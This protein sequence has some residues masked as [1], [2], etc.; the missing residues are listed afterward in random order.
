MNSLNKIKSMISTLAIE[1]V[2]I[3]ASLDLFFFFNPTGGCPSLP[4][5]GAYRKQ[6]YAYIASD[7]LRLGK[8]LSIPRSSPVGRAGA[9]ANGPG[10]RCFL[11]GKATAISSPEGA[12][13]NSAGH[14]MGR[15]RRHPKADTVDKPD[16]RDLFS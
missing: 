12:T 10:N 2:L 16:G 8:L 11:S 6:E 7:P 1:E 5:G 14:S 9:V 3:R 15:R 4:N 13:L